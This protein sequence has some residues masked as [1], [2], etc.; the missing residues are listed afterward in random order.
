MPWADGCEVGIF[1]FVAVASLS[2]GESWLLLAFH[3][4][5]GVRSQLVLSWRHLRER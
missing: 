5:C 3:S 1:A 4:T 2:F